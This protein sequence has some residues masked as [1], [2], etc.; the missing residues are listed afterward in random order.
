MDESTFD[1]L[2]RSVV[3]EAG[4]RR[5]MM[6]LLAGTVLG[7]IASHLA[8][9]EECDGEGK[10]TPRKVEAHAPGVGSR[11]AQAPASQRRERGRSPRA[12]GKGKARRA[13]ATTRRRPRRHCPQDVR[14]AMSA[15][16]ARMGP[17]WPTRHW[18]ECRARG[19]GPAATTVISGNASPPNNS[20]AM[21]GS[22]PVGASAVPASS[23][24][25][26]PNR[27]PAFRASARRPVAPAGKSVGTAASP[28]RAAATRSARSA[29]R[30]TRRPARMA[31]GPAVGR[32]ARTRSGVQ[33][34][35]AWPGPP[36]VPESDRVAAVGA[37]PVANAAR[38]STH[39]RA[40]FARPRG[41][42]ASGKSP[43]RVDCASTGTPAA[44]K[45]HPPSAASAK[46]PDAWPAVGTAGLTTPAAC[47][48]A[49]ASARRGCLAITRAHAAACRAAGRIGPASAPL[50]IRA[51]SAATANAAGTGVAATDATP[52]EP[53]R[54]TLGT[55][56]NSALERHQSG[57]TASMVSTTSWTPARGMVAPVWSTVSARSIET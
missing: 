29:A 28:P 17:A 48:V 3:T 16:C 11:L 2:T 44:P 57:T 30:V 4:T 27:P 34:A 50:A 36:A 12:S 55:R 52:G 45:W 14:T 26:I 53:G 25:P 51:A 40:A 37:S 5:A 33:A 8:P 38:A 49:R 7:A 9:P 43:V 15:R 56:L 22:V 18:R 31:R 47:S 21:T 23:T 24:A 35:H 19:A 6:R 41:H 20:R 32:V 10:V 39:V 13:N 42:A 54:R 1:A 46:W